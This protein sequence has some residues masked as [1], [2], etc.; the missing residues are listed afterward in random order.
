LAIHSKPDLWPA[1]VQLGMAYASEK[2]Y[3]R[4]EEVL[5]QAIVHD[6]DGS[7]HYR[8]AMVLRAEGKTDQAKQAFAEVRAIKD[9]RM[10]RV[11]SDAGATADQ[12]GNP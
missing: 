10:A 11:P 2:K 3:A 5:R 1:Y 8:L 9:E 4:A 7:V 6:V 12:G